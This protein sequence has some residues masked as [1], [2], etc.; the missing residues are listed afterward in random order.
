[1]AP[2]SMFAFARSSSGLPSMRIRSARCPAATVPNS[3]CAFKNAAVAEPRLLSSGR[4]RECVRL[5]RSQSSPRLH[6]HGPWE[7]RHM[8]DRCYIFCRA[9]WGRGCVRSAEKQNRD[10]KHAGSEADVRVRARVAACNRP[11]HRSV[12]GLIGLERR[13]CLLLATALLSEK[14]HGRLANYPK[15]QTF[16]ETGPRPGERA[17]HRI[18]APKT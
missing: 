8:D 7:Q 3:S 14:E 6:V 18:S 13:S 1:M 9:I 10:G 17:H 5:R 4:D 15:G 16:R 12:D 2:A 11:L